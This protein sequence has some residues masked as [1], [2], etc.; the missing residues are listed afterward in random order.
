M[1]IQDLR[2]LAKGMGIK[3][4]GKT[5]V[6]LIREIQRQEGNF[7]CYATAEGYCDQAECI[8]RESCISEKK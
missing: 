8:F 4:F 3:S 5:K 2:S 1:K 6:D 7:D